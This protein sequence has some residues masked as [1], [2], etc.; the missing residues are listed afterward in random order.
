MSKREYIV[1]HNYIV[2]VT[3]QPM[4]VISERVD[5][6]PWQAYV[7]VAAGN[8]VDVLGALREA[9]QNGREDKA[10]ELLP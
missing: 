6:G 2:P 5:G 7:E 1:T 3:G 10:E 4:H 9:Y 8:S